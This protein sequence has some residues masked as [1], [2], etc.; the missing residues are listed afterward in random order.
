MRALERIGIDWKDSRLIKNLYIG[1]TGNQDR[2][3]ELKAWKDR[4]NDST[5]NCNNPTWTLLLL[6]QHSRRLGSDV[7][8]RRSQW[9]Q[10]SDVKITDTTDILHMTV[11]FELSVNNNSKWLDR[12][13][14]W[15]DF[16]LIPSQIIFLLYRRRSSN[17]HWIRFVWIYQQSICQKTVILSNLK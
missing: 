2:W 11:E 4:K 12:A 6:N 13:R 5:T 7:V 15:Y 17:K 16:T 10:S 8:Q 3:N 9:S 1:Q 14:E